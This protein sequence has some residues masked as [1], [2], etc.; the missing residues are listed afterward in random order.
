MHCS[1]AV[2]SGEREMISCCNLQLACLICKMSPWCVVL[3]VT[4]WPGV[5][6]L[7]PL[8]HHSGMNEE[9]QQHP[10]FIFHILS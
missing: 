9:A 5:V 8:C 1:S 7:P 4:D 2:L 6:S 10:S 3:Q